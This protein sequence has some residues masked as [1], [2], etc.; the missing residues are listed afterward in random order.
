MKAMILAAGRG[1]RMR[2][3]TDTQPKP[4]LQA[5]GEALLHYP[6]A[7]LAR[8]GIDEV[9]INLAWR[10]EQIREFVGDGSRWGLSVR[11]SDEGDEALDTGGGIRQALPL[12]GRE[13]FWLVNAD[14]Y[15]DYP[16]RPLALPAGRLA[17]LVLVSNPAH[18]RRG[19]FCL[20]D[21]R[22]SAAD[23]ERLTYAGLAVLHPELVA[24]EQPG[25]FS[26]VPLLVAAM[27]RGMVGG[28][29]FDGCWTDVGTPQRLAELDRELRTAPAG[30]RC[31]DNG[32]G[33]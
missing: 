10:G 4:L 22:V 13:A 17:H 24:A 26:L 28:E 23:G 2:P 7:A 21:G 27:S 11:F 5:G 1:E 20:R 12:L 16:F 6:L 3:L 25:R 8:A 18:H 9:V 32:P 33:R 31:R 30:V 29:R 15:S 14:V 19:D